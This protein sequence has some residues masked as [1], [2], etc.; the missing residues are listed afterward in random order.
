MNHQLEALEYHQ[1]KHHRREGGHDNNPLCVIF[2]IKY[3]CIIMTHSVECIDAN[4]T[5]KE[6]DR[7][8]KIKPFRGRSS[9]WWW[10]ED[11]LSSATRFAWGNWET[12]AGVSRTTR[13][14]RRTAEVC[15]RPL[16]KHVKT[17]YPQ[18]RPSKFPL[19]KPNVRTCIMWNACQTYLWYNYI[20]YLT[21]YIS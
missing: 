17:H 10:D 11:A 2:I 1:R 21:L 13:A 5:D 14:A 15:M 4:V 19:K 18:S 9:G 8:Q 16:I 7:W 3:F 20:S 12:L 6:R